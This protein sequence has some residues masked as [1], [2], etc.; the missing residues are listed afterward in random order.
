[1]PVSSWPARRQLLPASL[2]DAL[3]IHVSIYSLGSAAG[4][5]ALG[6]CAARQ[7]MPRSA[8]PCVQRVPACAAAPP[9]REDCRLPL[10]RTHTADSAPDTP[11]G[12]IGTLHQRGDGAHLGIRAWVPWW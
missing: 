7:V 12:Y 1:M 9:R 4:A 5:G 10:T 2:K 8:A 3:P 6:T 11:V